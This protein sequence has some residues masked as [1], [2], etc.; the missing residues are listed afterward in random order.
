M[1]V[2]SA[3][4]IWFMNNL[5]GIPVDDTYY[6]FFLE[7]TLP[8]NFQNVY[9]SPNGTPWS[10]PVEFQP[11]AGLPNN[12]YFD[13][14]LTYRIQVRQGPTQTSPL[15]WDVQNF[16]PEGGGGTVITDTLTVAANS[17]VN[18]QFSDILFSSPFTY[19]QASASTYTLNI[20]PGW[21]LVLTGAGTTI[22]TQVVNPNNS[23]VPGNPPYYLSFNN[24]GWTSVKLIQTFENNGALFAGGA[25]AVTFL[26]DMSSSAQ[27]VTVVYVPS[28]TNTPT[29]LFSG[30]IQTGSLEPYYG[31]ANI[32]EP[33]N[34]SSSPSVQLVF[35]L[36]V[37]GTI[38]L[39][40]IQFVGQS[41]PLSAGFVLPNTGVY[42]NTPGSVP[43]FQQVSYETTVNQEFSFYKNSIIMQPKDTVLVGWNFGLNPWQFRTTSSTNVAT[44]TYTADQ[45]I[46]CQQA[47][48]TSATGNNVAVGQSGYA[49]NNGFQVTAVTANNQFAMIQYVDPVSISPYWGSI[50]SS[51]VNAFI[52]SPSHSTA[53]CQFKMRLIYNASL[54]SATSQSYPIASWAAGQDPVFASGWT[55]IAPINDPVYTLGASAEEFAFSGFQLPAAS[56]A[57]M[58]LGIVFYTISNMNQAATAD[59]I[60]VNDISL[61]PS[62]F[63]LPSN[64]KTWDQVLKECQYYYEKSYSNGVLPGATSL[65]SQFVRLQE[66]TFSSPNW[67]SYSACFDF[68][69]NTIK[70]VV[71]TITFYSPSA[72][73]SAHLDVNIYLNGSAGT[74][75]STALAGNWVALNVGTK[76]AS[77]APA[78]NATLNQVA[79]MSA[80]DAVSTLV[81]FH[82]VADARI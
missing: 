23:G 22:I 45:T 82:F 56:A 50:M 5:T 6:A 76:R 15:I 48:V 53:N 55:A 51:V 43:L 32:P 74:P 27:P 31:A 21:T 65:L 19:T 41:T 34:V 44:N 16:V 69:Y 3:N 71:P 47:Y 37:L 36:P 70:R 52:N 62:Q 38:S 58:T 35:N 49:T 12:L 29:T 4:P 57:T 54:P 67:L 66:T 60:V 78:G 80:S 18:P 9:M 42:P 13:P 24:L 46:I 73:T 17:I 72:G 33:V 59:A 10:N 79:E 25:A 40:N 75:A 28:G 77:Y 63:A 26:A 30:Q 11:S 20:A 2:R 1:F 8:Y 68:D 39:S 61:V 14:S 64:P 81:N 7:N